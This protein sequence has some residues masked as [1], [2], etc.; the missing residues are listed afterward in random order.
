MDKENTVWDVL[1]GKQQAKAF[2]FAD[3]YRQFLNRA[4]TERLAAESILS[5][6]KLRGFRSIE[7]VKSAK[8][9][10]KLYY[11]VGG[12]A[13][14]LA[15]LGKK[16]LDQG[17]RI[18]GSHLDAP[19]LDL[20]QQPL[21]EDMGLALGKTHYYGGIKK[22]QWTT[23]PLA[24]HGP[25]ITGGG[26]RVT[27]E[28]GE[29]EADPVFTITDLLPHLAKEQMDKKIREAV[30]GEGL[31]ILL[32]SIPLAGREVKERVKANL[33]QVLASKYGF[34]EEDLVSAELEAVPAG[35]ARMVGLDRGLIGGYGQDDR[36]CV[37]T[38]LMA[39]LD[40]EE[41]ESTSLALF[42]DKEETGSDGATGM[43]SN[44]LEDFVAELHYLVHG[45]CDG[46][47]LRRTL[48]R[49]QA[50]SADATVAFDP[51]YPDVTDKQNTACLGKGIVIMK[52]SGVAGKYDTSDANAEF[53]GLVRRIFN[54]AGI[55]WQTGEMGK[56]DQ[57]GGGTIAQFMARYGMEVL[58]CGPALLSIHSPF[59][60]AS[61]G[62]IFM[63]YLAYVEFFRS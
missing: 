6:A 50:L 27:V 13:L 51:N 18:I 55:V 28:I 42:T 57:G 61:V 34:K 45:S 43:K 25:V 4:K 14:C 15:V 2:E 36:A 9:G 38:S 48:R 60:L 54:Q 11:D 53:V 41:P 24:L 63:T 30:K 33:L 26:D 46:V 23:V 56:V 39:L 3:G 12:K 35:P 20:K 37:Y 44:L 22:Y 52:Y 29:D 40:I 21:Y 58:D 5:Q 10:D 8:P 32:G 19:R 62:D 16:P 31:N 17:L 7:E 59:E 47:E 1:D 49:S